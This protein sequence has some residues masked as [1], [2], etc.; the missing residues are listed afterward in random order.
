MPASLYIMKERIRSCVVRL[1][2]KEE[3]KQGGKGEGETK[4]RRKG[5]TQYI[6]IALCIAFCIF[7]GYYVL[8]SVFS[9]IL[10]YWPSWS[11]CA[12][13]GF[14]VIVFQQLLPISFKMQIN[15]IL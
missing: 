10:A 8:L 1:F 14:Q 7:L 6:R 9:T 2:E 11:S 4:E 12:V 5:N 13:K 15:I 3:R